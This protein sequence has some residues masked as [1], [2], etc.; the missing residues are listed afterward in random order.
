MDGRTDGWAIGL[1]LIN[2]WN[3]ERVNEMMD[4]QIIRLGHWMNKLVAG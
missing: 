3:G 2:E 4:R 1:R